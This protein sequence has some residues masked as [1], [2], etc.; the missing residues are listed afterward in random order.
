MWDVV[1]RNPVGFGFAPVG[2]GVGLGAHGLLEIVL[3]VNSRTV[4]HAAELGE[5]FVEPHVLSG[6][7]GGLVAKPHVRHLVCHIFFLCGVSCQYAAG[8]A[9]IVNMFHAAHAGDDVADTVERIRSEVV[10]IK[11]RDV[12]YVDKGARH[13]VYLIWLDIN[14]NRNIAF[15]AVVGVSPFDVVANGERNVVGGYFLGNLIVPGG[16]A[17]AIVVGVDEVA[18]ADGFC[19]VGDGNVKVIGGLVGEVV[20]A[21]EPAFA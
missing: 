11:C 9:D 20:H 10:F 4:K 17:V 14:R 15:N 1:E 16:S 21:G 8:D 6:G 13:V 3:A 7:A 18:S 19:A 5:A 12:L 2:D